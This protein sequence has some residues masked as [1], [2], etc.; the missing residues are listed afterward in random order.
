MAL[1]VDLVAQAFNHTACETEASLVYKV[2]AGQSGLIL[3]PCLKKQRGGRR[4]RRKRED[5]KMR[6]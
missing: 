6:V 2:F 4:K 3:R 5:R 1:G